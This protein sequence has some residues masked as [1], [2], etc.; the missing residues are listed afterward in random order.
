MGVSESFVQQTF[1]PS[2]ATAMAH[3]PEAIV[4]TIPPDLGT[5]TTLLPSWFAQSLPLSQLGLAPFGQV[6]QNHRIRG[7]YSHRVAVS[8]VPLQG[9]R[10][11]G[12]SCRRR[13]SD[14]SPVQHVLGLRRVDL[15]L[16][17]RLHDMM[18]SNT[19]RRLALQRAQE[20]SNFRHLV[21]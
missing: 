11:K 7:R 8:I 1:M 16:F 10:D 9:D 5:E 12:N 17:L 2:V 6:L 15:G 20:D 13:R 19:A 18:S 21:P 3:F 14:A 4:V